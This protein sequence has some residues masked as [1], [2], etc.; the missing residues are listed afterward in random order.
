M[1]NRRNQ[2]LCLLTVGDTNGRRSPQ[3]RAEDSNLSKP[4]RLLAAEG[5][6]RRTD[7]F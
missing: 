3:M 7:G 4:I 1:Q 5:Y 6:G 2:S